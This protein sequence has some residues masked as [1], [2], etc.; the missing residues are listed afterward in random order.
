M[1]TYMQT[2][3]RRDKASKS[4]WILKENQEDGQSLSSPAKRK[5]L[6]HAL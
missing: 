2:K 5:S 4:D 1:L 6:K 3:P